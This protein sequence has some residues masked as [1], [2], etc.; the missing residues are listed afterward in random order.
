M[1]LPSFRW[2]PAGHSLLWLVAVSLRSAFTLVVLVCMSAPSPCVHVSL[3]LFSSYKDPSHIGV[4]AHTLPWYDDILSTYILVT[5]AKTFLPNQVIFMQPIVFLAQF[6]LQQESSVYCPGP[7]WEVLGHLTSDCVCVCISVIYIMSYT[8][9]YTHTHK[10]LYIYVCV[11]RCM[12]KY[13]IYYK[14]HPY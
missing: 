4:R 13:F 3:G 2:L 10:C 1:L 6:N 14:I 11:Y 5:F 12:C 7:H 8:H 9:M